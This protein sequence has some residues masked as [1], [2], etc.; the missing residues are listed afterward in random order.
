MSDNRLRF[1]ASPYLLQHADNPVHWHPWG[2]AALDEAKKRDVPILLSIGYAACHWCHVMAHE[3]FENEAVAARMNELFVNIKVDREERPDIDNIYMQALS[4][5]G[6][7]GGW[8]LTM[9]LTPDGEPFWG[10][11]YFPPSSTQGRTGF[12]DVLERV[13][14]IYNANRDAVDKNRSSLLMHLNAINNARHDGSTLDS[15]LLDQMA[16]KLVNHV[17]PDHGGVGGAPKFPQPTAQEFLW[18]SFLRAGK[19]NVG[20]AVIR[21]L[22]HMAQ[23]GIYDHLGGGFARYTVDEAW[24]VPHF[25]KML[26][27][28]GQLIDLYTM[29]WQNTASPLYA[30]RIA[31]TIDW[32]AREMTVEG[33]GFA[34]SLNADSE[35][36]EGK[37]YVWKQEDIARL[38]PPED[39]DLFCETY[40]VTKQGNWENTNILNRLAAM[41][42]LT[43]DEESRLANARALLFR[44]REERIRPTCDDKVLTDWNGLTIAAL[45]RA[46]SVFGR[47]DWLQMAKT[48][49]AFIL[50]TL[51][52]DDGRLYH[53]ARLG[54]VQKT[55]LLDDHA[56]MIRASLALYEA[57]SDVDYLNRAIQWCDTVERLFLDETAGGYFTTSS[58][59]DPLILR[60]K[61]A[62]DSAQPSANGTMLDSFA[63]LFM[64]T[65]DSL[66]DERA[67]SLTTAFAGAAVKNFFPLTSFLNGYDT[68]TNGIEVRLNGD[69]AEPGTQE[70]IAVYNRLSLPS[71]VL[72]VKNSD[73]CKTGT[74]IVCAQQRCSAPIDDLNIFKNSLLQAQKGA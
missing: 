40:G 37:F 67:K 49:Y 6:Q 5:M 36:V 42:M 14:G 4:V 10:G 43:D 9:F 38:L 24:L 63:R 7:P 73:D 72:S 30:T 35:G 11:T 51:Q 25:E 8:P 31:E 18:R 59:A 53:A 12:S 47:D 46:S 29:V 23:G 13:S 45:A 21:T 68:Y 48:A 62:H 17:D 41:D 27:D 70:L 60:P 69:R 74:A 3:S 28:N 55:S 50:N 26:Y 22:D 71:S 1:E 61:S 58:D 19:D 52:A 15:G 39:L 34:S 56:Q 64:L 54:R 33:G 32:I 2:Q 16:D 57:T 20:D 65:G 44:E 66:W